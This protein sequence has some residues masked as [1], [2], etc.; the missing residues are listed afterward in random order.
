MS[1]WAME[2]CRKKLH[3]R[4]VGDKSAIDA[5]L[6]DWLEYVCHVLRAGDEIEG[7]LDYHAFELNYTVLYIEAC[8]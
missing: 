6:W 7:L 2:P 4:R 1:I 5:Q 3:V 8:N